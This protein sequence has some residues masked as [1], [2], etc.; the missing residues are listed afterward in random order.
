MNILERVWL[1][2]QETLD[3]PFTDSYLVTIGGRTVVL[4]RA[5]SYPGIDLT[6]VD[7][8]GA[9]LENVNL[10]NA[11]LAGANLWGAHLSGA[12]LEGADLKNAVLTGADLQDAVLT[13][14]DLGGARVDRK[15]LSKARGVQWPPN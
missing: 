12:I 11:R 3:S 15:A 7:L 10:K 13:G 6:G 14:A 2:L 9:H 8:H 1:I 4:K 5:G